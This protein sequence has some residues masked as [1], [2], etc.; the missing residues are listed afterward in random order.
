MS[1]EYMTDEF[2]KNKDIIVE[3]V[4]QNPK[5]LIHAHPDLKND[6]YFIR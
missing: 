2:K 1:L 4:L 6:L 5:A 3:A